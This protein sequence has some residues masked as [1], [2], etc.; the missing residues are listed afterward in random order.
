ML[1]WNQFAEGVKGQMIGWN[2]LDE[3]TT[4]LMMMERVLEQAE[5]LRAL[6]LAQ[7][8]SAELLHGCLLIH[9]GGSAVGRLI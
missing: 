7:C 5:C 9:W 6:P 2:D 8:Y 3:G 1:I 4:G